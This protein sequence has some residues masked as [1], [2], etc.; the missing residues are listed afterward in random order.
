[1]WVVVEDK[2]VTKNVGK[3]QLHA[4]MGRLLYLEEMFS[5]GRTTERSHDQDRLQE[6]FQRCGC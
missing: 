5:S 2:N 4:G 3:R 1:M 6:E